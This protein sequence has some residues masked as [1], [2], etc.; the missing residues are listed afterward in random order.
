RR[1]CRCRPGTSWPPS[2]KRSSPSATSGT[3][4]VAHTRTAVETD[5]DIRVGLAGYGPAGA[6][7]HAPLIAATP[8]LRLTAVV[9][10]DPAKA[11]RVR[12]EHPGTE[13]VRSVEELWDRCD[14]V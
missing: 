6:F 5:S 12:H 13:V 14:L 10:R 4:D 1:A 11:E 9:T 2:S 3:A 7:F 8:G